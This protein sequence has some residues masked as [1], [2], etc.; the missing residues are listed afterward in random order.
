[1]LVYLIKYDINYG[2]YDKEVVVGEDCLIVNGKKVFLLNS[3]DLKQLFWWEYDIDIVVEVIGKFNLKDK[4][5]GY[6]EVGVKKVILIV[7]G[8]NEDVIIVMGVNE[9]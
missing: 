7:L 2:R 9:D 6:I 3:C 8:K 1:M 4:V 5:M